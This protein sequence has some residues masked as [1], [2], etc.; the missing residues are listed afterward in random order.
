MPGATLRLGPG[1][2]NLEFEFTALSFTAPENVRFRYRLEGFNEDWI[3]TGTSR[4][5][6]YSRLSAGKYRF[7]VKACNNAGVWNDAG[8]ALGFIVTPFFW[9]TW[10]FRL[11]TLGA[12]TL[13]LIAIVRYVSFRRLR[14]QHRLR[15]LEQERA[16]ERERVRLAQ[17]LHDEIGA[18]LCR[19]SYLSEHARQTPDLACELQRQ[20]VSIS[21][22][23]R[24]V[25]NSLDGIVWAIN[26]QNDALER[27]VTY[28]GHRAREYFQET[29]TECELDIPARL[30]PHCLSSQ[31]RNHL[32]LAV[33]EAFTNVLKHSGATRCRIAI[34]S[35]AT[36][37]E[38]SIAD[39]GNGFDARAIEPSAAGSTAPLGDGLR[40]MRQRLGVIGGNCSVKSEPG[41]G[42][43]ICFVLPLA[44]T[45]CDC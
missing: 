16:L 40:N 18:K 35:D 27:V 38:I 31:S 19:I 3:E 42:T 10:W 7:V 44:V 34:S 14:L 13:S 5:A 30:P 21:D 6:A 17:D 1:H 26:P 33:Q 24:E 12:F 32:L 9:Q 41:G 39:N 37:L 36:A 43:T 15:G 4:R 11:T 25:L 2:R 29:G 20:I 28:L 23:S 8:A 45:S 22:S